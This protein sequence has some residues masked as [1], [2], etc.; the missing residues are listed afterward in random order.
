M[1]DFEVL[2]E[3]VLSV[4]DHPDADRLSLVSVRGYTCVSAKLDDGSH[5]YKAG[6]RVVYVPEGAVVP[7][8]LLKKGF[9]N[10]K[11]GKGFLAGSKG[12]RV[13]AIRLRGILSQGILFSVD[14]FDGYDPEKHFCL[15]PYLLD[16]NLEERGY[17][18][19][20]HVF[21]FGVKIG[22]DVAE[23]LGITKYEPAIPM[24]MDGEV[25]VL[26]I[27]NVFRFDIND[28]KK[29][30]DILRGHE[31][32]V[33]EKLH[34]T[35]TIFGYI[36][37]LDNPDLTDGK[38]FVSSKNMFAKGLNIKDTEK[39]RNENVYMKA[40]YDFDVKR[41]L[42]EL[43]GVTGAAVYVLGELYGPGIQDLHYSEEKPN[44]RAF[45]M[46]VK[47]KGRLH[48]WVDVYPRREYLIRA[49]FDLTPLLYLGQ[50]DTEVI[51]ELTSGKSTLDESTVREGVVVT[52]L[53]LF[54]DR[55]LGRHPVVKSVS[56]DYLL[57]KGGTEYN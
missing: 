46:A 7:E 24:S 19:N 56:P 2:V 38:F 33:E 8:W 22:D 55:W 17:D 44:F 14:P 31:V 25:T 57:R 41:K 28:I 53:E 39:N 30:P 32:A 9:W 50:Y 51:S 12:D 35:C 13:K 16:K 40:F 18:V 43:S 10:E 6:D 42:E 47:Y 1:A 11:E 37:W 15:V 21:P 45:G 20:R 27:E 52:P 26:G 5:R 48:E 23:M 34:G 36:P 49:G 29:Y 3:E 54:E 4:V